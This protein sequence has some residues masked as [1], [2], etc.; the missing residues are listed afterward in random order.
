MIEPLLLDERLR[1][2]G[3]PARLWAEAGAARLRLRDDDGP[4]GE[5]PIA[6]VEVVMRR[7]GRPLDPEVVVEGPW[8]DLGGGRRLRRLRYHAAVDATG[9]D[10]L[11]WE[12]EGAEPLA[13]MATTVA[14]ALRHLVG[15]GV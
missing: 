4:C 15:R 1:A 7:Y 8:L 14:A 3:S 5:L 12:A 11:V 13:A 9:R 6:A 2:D 10:Y